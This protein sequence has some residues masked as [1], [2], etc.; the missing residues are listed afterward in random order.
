MSDPHAA[1]KILL[2]EHG[3]REEPIV[4]AGRGD[5]LNS[6]EGTMETTSARPLRGQTFV[7]S[8][9]PGAGKT[10]LLHKL[11]R[12]HQGLCIHFD[13]VP[14]DNQIK[15]AWYRLAA[16]FTGKSIDSFRTNRHEEHRGGSGTKSGRKRNGQPHSGPDYKRSRYRCVHGHQTALDHS[17]E[18]ACDDLYR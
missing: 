1:L 3:E 7:I 10:A 8:G 2:L 11:S 5:I 18:T 13:E 15:E 9:A 6:I 16:H 14:T 17:A 12:Q 4:F